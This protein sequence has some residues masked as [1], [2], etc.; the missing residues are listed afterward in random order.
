MSWTIDVLRQLGDPRL[1]GIAALVKEF[2]EEPVEDSSPRNPR[3]RGSATRAQK[4]MQSRHILFRDAFPLDEDTQELLDRAPPSLVIPDLDIWRSLAGTC[5]PK[6]PDLP[7]LE[8]VKT[9]MPWLQG[10]RR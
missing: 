3:P 1:E 7:G 2:P 5:T 4:G 6:A 9:P 10:T 8:Q